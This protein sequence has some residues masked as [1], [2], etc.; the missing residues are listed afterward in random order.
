MMERFIGVV[1]GVIFGSLVGNITYKMFPNFA[2]GVL[3]P[4]LCLIL[5]GT[6]TLDR[7]GKMEEW[8]RSDEWLP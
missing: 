1:V 6:V 5:I 2:V 3:L 7:S 8:L 4:I